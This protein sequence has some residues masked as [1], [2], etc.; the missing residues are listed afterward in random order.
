MKTII[1]VVQHLS[2]GGLETMVLDMLAF[3]NPNY[4]IMVVSLEGEL[5]STI[6]RWPRLVQYQE[7]I[8]CLDKAPGISVKVIKQLVR[9]FT[10]YNV[11]VVHSHHIGP[12]LYSG[13]AAK[14]STKVQHIHTEHDA[15]HLNEKK[16]RYIQK[17]ILFLSKPT[18]VADAD[19]VKKTLNTVFQS[20]P[21]Y[22]IKNGIDPYKFNIGNKIEARK[23][24]GV[25]LPSNAIVVGNAARLELI[26]GQSNL[27]EAMAFLD[28]KYHLLLA[29]SGG[30]KEY[31]H[32]LVIQ[33]KLEDRVHFLG[34]IDHMPTF[35]QALDL[36]C[37][38]SN[39]EG[40]PLSTLEAQSC[41]IPC[42][43]N[44]VGGVSETLCPQHS[45]LVNSNLP[46]TLTCAINDITKRAFQGSPREF[47]LKHNNAKSMASAYEAL[48]FP[49]ATI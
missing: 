20:Y 49:G 12:M 18:L 17:L 26:K 3:T 33:Y 19:F 7:Q 40:F 13:L 9:I 36:F 11:D 45:Q 35:Y 34:H 5:L 47:I 41:G 27:I 42:V 48:Y 8:I 44:N 39:N 37:L 10:R 31:L 32:N 43:A 46:I 6:K 23:A 22:T 25:Y 1:H 29:G 24:L 4:R 2:P 15:W 38:P 30:E 21:I 16:D 14:L 28:K